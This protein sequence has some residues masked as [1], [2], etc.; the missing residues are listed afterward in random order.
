L[1]TSDFGIPYP[2][3]ELKQALTDIIE[4]VSIGETALGHILSTESE[5][6]EKAK[7]DANNIDELL[8]IYRACSSIIRSI[9]TMQLFSHYI[10]EDAAN[11]LQR[12]TDPGENDY[13]E[14]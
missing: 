1:Q 3:V 10:L 9:T 13:L 11:L 12:I 14:E 7:K 5:L 4:S 6:L 2:A 8:D